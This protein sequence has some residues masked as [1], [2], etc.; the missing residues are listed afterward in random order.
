MKSSVFGLGVMS[1]ICLCPQFVYAQFFG[2]LSND[3]EEDDY[4]K[5]DIARI[6]AKADPE[7]ETLTDAKDYCQA[8]PK[9]CIGNKAVCRSG[10]PVNAY[11]STARNSIYRK[12]LASYKNNTK[13]VCKDFPWTCADFAQ[14]LEAAKTMDVDELDQD[15]P[16]RLLK[17]LPKNAVVCEDND[18]CKGSEACV[19][20]DYLKTGTIN[21]CKK[22]Y[23]LTCHNDLNCP[24]EQYC[25]HG[26][27]IECIDNDK[28]VMRLGM[29]CSQGRWV[30]DTSNG[31]PKMPCHGN[32][33]CQDGFS[34]MRLIL[35]DGTERCVCVYN[36]NSEHTDIKTFE[37][38]KNCVSNLDCQDYEVCNTF[39]QK[40]VDAENDVNLDG[41]LDDVLSLPNGLP[42]ASEAQ[43]KKQITSYKKQM[44][45][46]QDA[47]VEDGKFGDSMDKIDDI[48]AKL[49]K[50]ENMML[51]YDKFHYI[52]EIMKAKNK[53]D[54]MRHGEDFDDDNDDGDWDSEDW[55]ITEIAMDADTE[56]L[57]Y[58]NGIIYLKDG[59]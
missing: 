30:V 21:V 33:P 56:T 52:D 2:I 1:L 38:N 14:K 11:T 17:Q 41:V 24:D 25:Y 3:A 53:R 22:A 55:N 27:C 58:L 51:R 39:Y 20:Y 47:A 37:F 50:A 10:M 44:D 32:P 9:N 46:L 59:N 15:K 28:T 29:K 48:Q 45:K 8:Y 42:N 5:G 7:K 16:S 36:Y 13:T 35:T 54:K 57:N 26:K 49:T 23:H 18:D 31:R 12:N 4:Y 40:C 19:T 6:C 43:L 34:M